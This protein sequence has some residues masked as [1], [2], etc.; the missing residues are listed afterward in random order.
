MK[1]VLKFLLP[2]FTSK[3][4]Y[5]LFFVPIVLYIATSSFDY[6][7]DDGLYI[8]SNTFTQKGLAGIVDH[9]T[10]EALTGFYGEQKNLLTGGR[11]RPLAPI[12]YT[13]EYALY[14]LKPGMSHLINAILYGYLVL[15]LFNL[16]KRYSRSETSDDL[17]FFGLLLFAT[18]PIHAE[19]VA[20]IK[21]RDQLMA[22]LFTLSSTSYLLKYLNGEKKALILSSLL[23][24]LALLS[25]ESAITFLPLIP[26]S[27]YIFDRFS[28]K[29]TFVPFLVLTGTSVGWFIIRAY[30]IQGFE[31]VEATTVLN[32]PF[33]YATTEERY[34]TLFAVL[35]LAT[36]LLIIP[37]PLTHDY[38]PFHIELHDWSSPVVWI[39]IA[40]TIVGVGA[41]LLGIAKT[42]SYGFW[43][44]MFA[45]TYSISSNVLFNIGS[46]FNERF[47]F[48]AS[49]AF[50]MLLA[51][52]LYKVIPLKSDKALVAIAI[53][54]G[55][56]SVNRS[57]AWQNNYTLFTTDVETSKNSVKALM[58]AGG[59]LLDD[60]A[61][62]NNP[63]EKAEQLKKSISYLK[64]ATELL[65]S[66]TN[67]F[68]LLGNAY[69][70]KDGVS[71][72]VVEAYKS[73][74]QLIPN[75]RFLAD[76]VNAILLSARNSPRKRIAF[77]S[78][79]K[80]ELET[81]PEYHY[82]MGLLYGQE[83]ND[84]S[85]GLALFKKAVSLDGNNIKYLNK[86]GL[87]QGLMGDYS[88]SIK[89]FERSLE[90]Q[91]FNLEALDGASAGYYKMGNKAKADELKSLMRQ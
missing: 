25:K 3:K 70:Q 35:L 5:F 77:G 56:I 50:C 33:L 17:I 84:L 30:I 22:N 57:F 64:R 59:S 91:P 88:A 83:L 43:L 73:G 38:Y 47:L 29:S 16:F 21:G 26:L 58:A 52:F 8:T 85:K 23:F 45:A 48:E 14:G 41:T 34:A 66:E 36:R 46:F 7:L 18:H 55:V 86:V 80:S 10:N 11:Y 62:Q 6:A 65:P 82:R 72:E 19:V 60:A 42:K 74:F 53:F 76:N 68:R 2:S 49:L 75:D 31:S 51:G 15:G 37:Y 39:G 69:Y 20:N 89:T 28:L 27:F 4:S 90:I 71:I 67:A 24:F 79:F 40:L 63:K 12:T 78:A 61:K 44:L 87:V 9:L 1:E 81:N 54:F 32:D 13:L